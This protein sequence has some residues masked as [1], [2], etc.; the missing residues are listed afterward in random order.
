MQKRLLMAA[1]YLLLGS[2]LIGLTLQQDRNIAKVVVKTSDGKPLSLYNASYAL[3]VGVSDY[4]NGWPD[5]RE[6]VNDA[7]AVNAALEQ[8]G[9]VVTLV[10]T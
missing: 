5:L 4:T 7:R 8:Q 9:F 10:E 6:A 1:V 2:F 3:V